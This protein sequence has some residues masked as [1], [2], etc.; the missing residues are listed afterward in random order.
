MMGMMGPGMGGGSWG[1]M[2][3]PDLLYSSIPFRSPEDVAKERYAKGEI[4]REQ[5]LQIIEDL[6]KTQP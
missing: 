5:Y 3:N 6:K 2:G 4:S 1:M